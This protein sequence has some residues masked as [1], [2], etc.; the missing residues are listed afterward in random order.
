MH[1][2][3]RTVPTEPAARSASLMGVDLSFVIDRVKRDH[4][5]WTEDRINA[6]VAE[7]REYLVYISANRNLHVLPPLDA[8]EVWHAHIIH[9]RE[10]AAFC[11]EHFGQF[12]HHVP[13]PTPVMNVK[14]FGNM[15]ADCCSQSSCAWWT[16]E[17]ISSEML[18]S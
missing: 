14:R 1:I 4:P 8:D 16:P 2:T 3:T 13:N 7:Y 11:Q 15:T 6:A 9:T 5:D 10:Y 17:E 18:Q 12:L